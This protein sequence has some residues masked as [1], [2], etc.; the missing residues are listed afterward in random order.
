[1][2]SK[3]TRKSIPT[4]SSPKRMARR[5]ALLM[6]MD[7]GCCRNLIRGIHAY[8]LERQD[9]VLR[10]SPCDLQV[11]SFLRDW[12]PDGIIATVFDR[13][14]GRALVRLRRPVVDTAYTLDDLKLPVVDVDHV[15]VGRLAAEHL[16]ERGYTRFGF[17][18]SQSARYSL[19]RA[20][21][22]VQR[23]ADHGHSASQCLVEYLYEDFATSSWKK[24]E[25]QIQ[26]WVRQ[27]PKPVG[28]FACN[29]IAGR[30]LVDICRQLGLNVPRDV[31]ILGADDDELESL[32]TVP[33]LSSVAIP[34]KR[35]GYE[36]ARTLERMMA[37]EQAG[38]TFFLPPVRVI[39]RQSTDTRATD[40]PAIAEA[41]QYIRAH[42]AQ[43][44]G[45]SEVAEAVGLGRRD[46]ERKFRKLLGC[47]V[48]DDIRSVRVQRVRELLAGTN[49][50]MP[51]IAARSGFSS[52]ERMAVVFGQIAGMSPTAYRRWVSAQGG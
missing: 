20:A 17:L 35:V 19:A 51:T 40:N 33:P 12:R 27:L 22:Y 15:A 25:P 28:I 7:L 3:P 11:L 52:A 4:P 1:M 45:V 16:L 36:A 46:L 29:D 38:E 6:D 49:L 39:V 47:S 18:G 44:I 10:N 32:L 2:A 50:A 34:A 48:L 31:A 9:W 5:V 14:I 43:N 30:G 42:A 37:G 26:Q 8:A 21:S 41:L 23:L 13:K 24:D